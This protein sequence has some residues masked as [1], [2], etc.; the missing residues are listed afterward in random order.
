M[1]DRVQSNQGKSSSFDR[2]T[3]SASTVQM[4]QGT[5][6]SG[7]EGLCL[8][9]KRLAYP[10]RYFDVICRFARPV[11][12]LCRIYNIVLDWININHGH[13]LT[14]WNQLFLTPAWL[15]QYARAI[16]QIGCP[17]ANCLGFIDGTVRPISRPEEHQRLVSHGSSLMD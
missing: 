13:R 9:L 6:C 10:C 3:Q 12:E 17:L 8:L 15:E 7:I 5:L 2:G 11:P 14:P 4:P 1:F 16:R